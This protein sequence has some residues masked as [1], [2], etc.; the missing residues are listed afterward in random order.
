[1]K[2]L[3]E[4]TLEELWQLFPIEL[5]NHQSVY[6][7]WYKAEEKKL[8]DLLDHKFIVQIHHIGSTAV[9]RL[10]AKPIVDILL[11]TPINCDMDE[12]I[13]LLEENEWILMKKD[14][15]AQMADLNKGYTPEGF[16][17][18]VF[19]LHIKPLGNHDEIYFRNYLR[20]HPEVAREYEVLKQ[21]LAQTY[22]YHRDNYTDGKTAFVKKYTQKAKEENVL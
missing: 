19:H 7:D 4:L 16:A 2:N 6:A 5:C 1:M 8:H 14:H 9:E 10:I 21:E 12:M 22:K 20:R 3:K 17:K 15:L 18:K 13:H 11:E